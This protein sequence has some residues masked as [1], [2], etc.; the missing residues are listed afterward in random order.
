MAEFIAETKTVLQV[1]TR[2]YLPGEREKLTRQPFNLVTYDDNNQY[3]EPVN[4]NF[5]A[6]SFFD[7]HP[8]AMT[9]SFLISDVP[10]FSGVT[11]IR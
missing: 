1:Y 5:G 2:R 9:I 10:P 4:C 6:Y 7:N 3:V 11:E 8:E